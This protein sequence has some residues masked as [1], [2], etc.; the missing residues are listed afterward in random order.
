MLYLLFT[1]RMI[2]ILVDEDKVLSELVPTVK[3]G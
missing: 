2:G 3:V 1:V